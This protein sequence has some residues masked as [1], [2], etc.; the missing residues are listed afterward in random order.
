MINAL[1]IALAQCNVTVGDIRGNAAKILAAVEDA[2]HKGGDLIVFPEMALTGYPAEDLLFKGVFQQAAM[3][4]VQTITAH[5]HQCGIAILLGSLW[6]QDGQIYNSALLMDGGEIRA[7]RHKRTLPNYGVFDEKRLFTKGPEP[8]VIAWRG[9][10]L[11]VLVC[12]DV[13]DARWPERLSGQGAE[14]LIVLNASPY[15]TGK[16]QDR[17]QVVQAAARATR[18]PVC[19]LNLIGGQDELVFDG[20]SFLV[21]AQ[22]TE[23]GRLTAFGEELALTEWRR[24]EAAASHENAAGG[25]K[26][27]PWRNLSAAQAEWGGDLETIYQALVLGLRDYVGKNRFEGVVIGLSGGIDSGLTA[28]VAVDALG[29]ERVHGL[30]MPSRY[31]SAQSIEDSEQLAANLGIATDTVPIA[32]AMDAY[33]AMLAPLFLGLPAD[34]TEENIQARIRGNVLMAYS[35]KFGHMLVTTGNKSEMS[36][37]YSTLYGDMCGGYSVLKD[38]Y[39]T[40][41][42]KLARWRNAHRFVFPTAAPAGEGS[43]AV[44]PPR[45]ISK[46]PTAELSYDQTDQD[47]LP[48]YEVLDGILIG[49]IDERCAIADLVAAGYERELVERVAKMIYIAEYKRRQAPPGVKVTGMSFGRDRRYPITNQWIWQRN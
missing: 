42:W 15:E 48:P 10:R 36:V 11:G 16:A 32:P 34:A 30:L 18:A 25:G 2:A 12:E 13:W 22:G 1:T 37:G 28:A 8:D 38:V 40:T 23:T 9:L 33:E 7:I 26:P 14:L 19:Y 43:A 29:A 44:I 21:D 35:N 17:L 20:R 31:T 5:S 27:S 39:K 4:A 24:D 47:T 49:L 41:V 46:P 3:D 45:M 6:V